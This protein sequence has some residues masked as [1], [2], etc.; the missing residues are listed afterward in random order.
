M[1]HIANSLQLFRTTSYRR[2]VAVASRP[3]LPE[4]L[5]KHPPLYRI[6][7]AMSPLIA[8]W[9]PRFLLRPIQSCLTRAR[10]SSRTCAMSLIRLRRCSCPRTTAS[11]FRTSSGGPSRLPLVMPRSPM[12]PSPK[13]IAS[14]MPT[15]PWKVSR[16]L[17]LCWLPTASSERFVSLPLHFIC[18]RA[19]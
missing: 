13:R 16:P 19:F 4:T 11:F 7:S 15:G 17:V 2:L 18:S 6:S 8:P 12:C 14:K 9:T 10:S 1:N 3:S 5:T